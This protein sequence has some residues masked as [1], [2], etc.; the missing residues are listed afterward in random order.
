VLAAIGWL[1]L[2]LVEGSERVGRWGTPMRSSLPGARVSDDSSLGRV[3]RRIGFAA[4]GA[5]LVIPFLTPGL[6]HRLVGN[7][8]GDGE[9]SGSGGGA[10][11]AQTYNPITRLTGY[12]TQKKVTFFQYVTTDPHPDYIR[13]T[14]L[15]LYNDGVWSASQLRADPEKGQAR[16]GIA[17]PDGQDGPHQPFTMQIALSNKSLKV[18]WLPVPYG[19]TDV[20]VGPAWL[21]EKRSQTI[22]SAGD[23]TTDLTSYK[24][25]ADRA[26][27]DR[28]QLQAADLADV[29]GDVNAHYGQPIQVTPRVRSIT[30]G[31][32]AGKTSEYDKAVA[33]QDYFS[34]ANDFSYS[35]EASVAKPGQDKLEGFLEGK[36][37]FCEQYATAMAVMLRVAGIPSRVAVGFTA[38]TK[39]T[40]KNG[41]DFWTVTT[42]EAHAWPEAWFPGTGWVRFEP[43]PAAV[44]ASVPSYTSVAPLDSGPV[45]PASPTPQASAN[46]SASASIS[47]QLKDALKNENATAAP[48]SGPGA[49]GSGP[50]FW[51]VAPIVAVVL[52]VLPFLLTVLRRRQRWTR[53]GA[54]TA[55][56]QLQDDATDIGYTWRASDSPRA[57]ATR[58]AADIRLP[59]P[60]LEALRTLATEAERARYAPEGRA[61][62]E[63]LAR[64]CAV[65]RGALHAQ[66]DAR[67]RLRALLF[68]SSTLRWASSGIGERLSRALDAV[69]DAISAATRPLRR[70]TR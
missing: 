55:W 24:V 10:R 44:G 45:G 56:A 33:I 57:A 18:R 48:S 11:Q 66:A 13:M 31:I 8:G 6:D 27:P 30:N 14:T 28:A 63:S 12:L 3:G 46:P 59:A 7:G 50:S 2:L 15:D 64:E 61:G 70:V 4:V 29:D 68:P 54:L 35:L 69:D 43:T 5:A 17:T 38:G 47:K 1:G 42:Q 20:N 67:V 26:L 40:D 60:A 53:P 25:N 41:Q 51:L 62:A 34:P 21:W 23:T 32:I 52:L 16:K 9:G 65:V 36:K 19:P 22:F 39:A 58:L 37:G 49:G